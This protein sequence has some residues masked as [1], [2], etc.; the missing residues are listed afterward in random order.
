MPSRKKRGRP[1]YK[2]L[3]YDRQN[4][5]HQAIPP[6]VKPWL[7][8]YGQQPEEQDDDDE[9]EES[10]SSSRAKSSKRMHGLNM[11]YHRFGRK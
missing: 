4:P 11:S 9:E 2:N 6:W 8:G 7:G 10:S 5:M 1:G 3:P